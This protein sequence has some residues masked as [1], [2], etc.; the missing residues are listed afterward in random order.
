MPIANDDNDAHGRLFDLLTEAL[1]KAGAEG[2]TRQDVIPV[3]ADFLTALALITAGEA[4]VRA[5]MTRME[6][7]IE[8]WKA[9][10]FPERP[11]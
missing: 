2:I 6:S 5:V 1:Q 4:G 10:R 8:D 3:V 7:R 9:E 11:R